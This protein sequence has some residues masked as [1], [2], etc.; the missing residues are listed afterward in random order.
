MTAV[1]LCPATGRTVR[2]RVSPLPAKP[3]LLVGT[4]GWLDEVTL[5]DSSPDGCPPSP[6]ASAIVP[7]RP[8]GAHEPPAATLTVGPGSGDGVVSRSTVTLSALNTGSAVATS[9]APM[10][11]LI[12]EA[13][14][15]MAH[16]E[17]AVPAVH[18]AAA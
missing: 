10:F 2:L 3:M 17:P 5:S 7:A 6:S 8:L 12:D 13:S 18:A 4:R 15:L 16:G 1:P 9:C 14:M 11:A